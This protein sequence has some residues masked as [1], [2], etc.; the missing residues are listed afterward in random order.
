MKKKIPFDITD[1]VFQILEGLRTQFLFNKKV[2]RVSI[3]YSIYI[4]EDNKLLIP[5]LGNMELKLEPILST[6]YTF[7]S[8]SRGYKSNRSF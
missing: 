7:P 3:P 2:N 4:D 5:Q 1:Q 8:E 6:L